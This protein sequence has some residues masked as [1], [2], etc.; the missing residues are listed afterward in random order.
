MTMEQMSALMKVASEAAMNVALSLKRSRDG[1]DDAGDQKGKRHL[2]SHSRDAADSSAAMAVDEDGEAAVSVLKAERL[3]RANEARELRAAIMRSLNRP[4]SDRSLYP[5]P[6]AVLP[7]SAASL[8]SAAATMSLSSSA[9][10]SGAAL[11][12]SAAS[13]AAASNGSATVAAN[14]KPTVHWCVAPLTTVPPFS[15]YFPFRRVDKDSKAAKELAL[16]VASGDAIKVIESFGR[17][18][19]QGSKGASCVE[20]VLQEAFYGREEKKSPYGRA[21][22][23]NS[24]M[25]RYIEAVSV[26]DPSQVAGLREYAR[27]IGDMACVVD[28]TA[29]EIADWEWRQKCANTGTPINH[30]AEAWA[31]FAS[32]ARRALEER[33]TT[34]RQ[35]HQQSQGGGRGGQR[36]RGQNRDGGAQSGASAASNSGDAAATNAPSEQRRR[37]V[38]YR[39]NAEQACNETPCPFRHVC[40]RRSCKG[41]EASHPA[42]RCPKRKAALAASTEDANPSAGASSTKKE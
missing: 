29:L 33:V 13:S 32:V 15:L 8:P 34:P 10:P 35:H 16:A 30:Y 3:Q 36:G 2:H 21:L 18:A 26:V 24:A 14:N 4:E 1:D 27:F 31:L 25:H 39:Y 23:W 20:L 40:N 5:R 42:A 6:T 37:G 9:N 38:C 7:V 17:K 11:I 19:L 22:E 41:A 28:F 12:A